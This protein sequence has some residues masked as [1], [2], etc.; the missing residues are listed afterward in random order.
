M[1][2]IQTP[3]RR[4]A[5]TF[6]RITWFWWRLRWR[7]SRSSDPSETKSSPSRIN[8]QLSVKASLQDRLN[9]AI[10]WKYWTIPRFSTLRW[11]WFIL[12]T[13]YWIKVAWKITLEFNILNSLTIKLGVCHFYQNILGIGGGLILFD[14]LCRRQ[15]GSFDAK[16]YSASRN[17]LALEQCRPNR[18]S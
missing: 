8:C 15:K 18:K 17:D 9:Y 14:N 6:S 10:F 5:I 2:P 12:N 1:A 16:K 7:P 13:S 3:T 4:F 11:Q